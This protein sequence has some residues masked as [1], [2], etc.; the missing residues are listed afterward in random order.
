MFFPIA[1]LL[2]FWLFRCFVLL[3]ILGLFDLMNTLIR[4]FQW[5]MLN[6]LRFFVVCLWQ[7]SLYYFLSIST[8]WQNFL[9]S[10]K[11]WVVNIIHIL[12][13]KKCAMVFLLV[14]FFYIYFISIL[15]ISILYLFYFP[16]LFYIYFHISIDQ[17]LLNLS[18]IF[19]HCI[20]I[21]V[22]NTYFKVL[23]FS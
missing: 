16:Y 8:F 18:I 19:R 12:S 9:S 1:I 22:L 11:N 20:S 23:I 6:F 7:F 21:W 5:D 2:L 17:F 4:N 14:S 10:R 3:S 15:F 13:L